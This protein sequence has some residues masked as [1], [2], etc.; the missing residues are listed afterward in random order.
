MSG[1]VPEGQA[2]RLA[3]HAAGMVTTARIV[4]AD[5]GWW[6]LGSR[7]HVLGILNVTP[8][9]FS[10]G[11]LFLDEGRAADHA[12]RMACEGADGVDI[13]AESS[14]PGAERVSP[15][16]ES[17][18]LLPVLRRVRRENPRLR[19]S[20]DTTRARIASEALDEGADMIND[21][22]A[23]A[24]DPEMAAVVAPA[25]AACV[26]MHMRGEPRTMQV[27]PLYGDLMGEISTELAAAIQRAL[28]AGVRE[29]AI[30]ID[31][32]IGF[33][34]SARHNLQILRRLTELSKLRRPIMVGASR[35]SFIGALTGAEVGERLEGS[36]G[37]SAAAVTAGASLLRVHDVGA[38]VR[39][40]RVVD[41]IV[42][43]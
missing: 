13:G 21:I 37:A 16:E 6:E 1:P 30:A 43:A 38:T 4:F 36:L 26:L 7:T 27:N 11:G 35:K 18:R 29:E 40:L 15:E 42:R 14:R 2:A 34:K 8:D 33:G 9:S 25:R 22:S 17:R 28:A 3:G 41:A 12:A 10:D 19:I 31:P 39:M 5:G 32:G 20:V 23:F 24:A